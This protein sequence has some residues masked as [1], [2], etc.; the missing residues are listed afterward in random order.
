MVQAALASL[1]GIRPEISLRTQVS[2]IAAPLDDAVPGAKSQVW[3]VGEIEAA[4]AKS[5]DWANGGEAQVLLTAEDGVKLAD[6]D[7]ADP[8]GL[9]RGQRAAARRRRWPLASSRC[10]SA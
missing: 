9:T 2:W 8:A 7:A 4:S 5:A 6:V 1:A 3:V 10:A